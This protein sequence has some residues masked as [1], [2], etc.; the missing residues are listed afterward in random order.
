MNGFI[1]IDRGMVDWGW[2]DDSNTKDVFLHLIL[3]ANW[4]ETQYHGRTI[5]AGQTVFG[6]QALAERLGMSVRNVRTALEH[7]K[8]TGEIT[9][10]ATNKF[11]IATLENWAKYQLQEEEV[12]N[13]RQT[14]DKRLTT[15]KEKKNNNIF[16]PPTLG[17]VEAYAKEKHSPVDY[18]F[19]WNYYNES[20]WNGVKNWKQKFLTWDRKERECVGNTPKVERVKY[21]Y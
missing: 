8:R 15:P 18:E 13:N 17:E 19:F 1:K 14:T 12:T 11:S 9:V 16:R 21:D 3:T 20:D 2:Y 4:K 7:L 5:K 10:E 6:I